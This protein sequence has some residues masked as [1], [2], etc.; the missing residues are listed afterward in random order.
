MK[1]FIVTSILLTSFSSLATLFT[2]CKEDEDIALGDL[3]M[4]IE[5]IENLVLPQKGVDMTT[6]GSGKT[7]VIRSNADWKFVPVDEE[8]V[9]W[10]KIFPMEGDA[11]GIIR[12]YC[13]PNDS[14]IKRTA[15]YH[16]VLNGI[17]QPE[18]L[19]FAQEGCSPYINVGSRQLTFERK[20]GS[21]SMGVT[22][23][24]DWDCSIEGKDAE[25][26][27]AS[28]VSETTA[29]VT[30]K[31][32]NAQG[33]ELEALLVISGK[34]EFADLRQE[35]NIT[36]LD[37]TFFDNFDW[38]ESTAGIFGWKIDTGQSEI[39][40][41]KWSAAE[42][43]HGWSSLST[44]VYARTGF[45]KF[46]KG[47]YGGDLASPTVAQL[48][49]GANVSVSWKALG[50]GTAKSVKD[51]IDTYYVAVLGPGRITS[52]SSAGNL[53]YTIPYRNE[54][55]MDITLEAVKFTLPEKAWL[56]P[57]IDESGI[58]VWQYPTSLFSIEVAGMDAT[59]RVIFISGDGNPANAY[60]NANSHNSRFFLDDY[61][62][63]VN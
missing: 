5:N 55:G 15:E 17:E 34:D 59:S 33:R 60:Q 23:N 31:G 41:D 13:D 9:A 2:G 28:K 25:Y 8:S 63:V 54:A 24:V 20:G 56:I 48:G 47:G 12:I 45:L 19:T 62:I 30:A 42:K 1:K 37:A 43:A 49:T 22:A 38:L 14:P 39:R 11:D 51:D 50:Y 52:C 18:L 32:V 6:F 44:W 29:T 57:S 16:I 10:A 40:I 26:F 53:G 7:F 58:E 35:V 27:S 3:Y 21:V 36:Q 61:K 46:G 4:N